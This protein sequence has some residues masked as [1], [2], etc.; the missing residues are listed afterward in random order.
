MFTLT[1]YQI[2]DELHR[3]EKSVVYRANKDGKPVI[4]KYLNSEY[5]SNFELKNFKKEYEILT[6]FN[7][8]NSLNLK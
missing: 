3:G 4:L 2:K 8:K 6:K 7:L 1:G 5:P